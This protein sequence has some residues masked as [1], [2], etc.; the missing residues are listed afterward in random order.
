MRKIIVF[1]MDGTLVET[2]DIVVKYLNQLSDSFDYEKLNKED[3]RQL[4]NT[5]SIR[6]LK[7]LG[8]PL[9]KA[10]FLLK[11]IQQKLAAKIEQLPLK[12]GMD[13]VLIALKKQGHTL[14]VATSNSKKN[15]DLFFK[16]FGGRYFDFRKSGIIPFTKH[17]AFKKIAKK[18]GAKL[19]D[20]YYV[21]DETRDILAAKKAGISVIA[22]TWGFNSREILESMDPDC[23]AEKPEDILAF[24]ED[25]E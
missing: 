10:P 7:V 22:V 16:K 9:W 8:I 3:V 11:K 12:N 13:G 4:R 6:F 19:S 5:R 1:D 18:I 2:R 14:G 25:R 20:I 17:K 24:F 15:A 21:G 23:I